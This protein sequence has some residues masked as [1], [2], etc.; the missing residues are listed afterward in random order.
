MSGPSPSPSSQTGGGIN[1]LDLV[2]ELEP[3]TP[4][5]RERRLDS[6]DLPPE[7]RRE[8]ERCLR[9]D[10][11]AAGFLERPPARL[12]GLAADPGTEI[13]AADARGASAEPRVPGYQVLSPLG[14]GG[15]GTVW[16]AV[17]LGTRRE[18]ALKLMHVSV[19]GQERARARFDREVQIAARLEHPHI[20]RVYDSGVHQGVYYYAMELVEGL[21]L[22]EYTASA[23]L[24]RRQILD[25]MRAVCRAVQHAHQNGVIHRDLK[26][27]NILVTKDGQPKVL[28]FGLARTVSD[29]GSDLTVTEEGGLAGTPAYMSPEQ[30][31]GRGERLDTRSDVYSLGVVLY[32]LLTGRSPHDLTGTRLELL[33]RISEREITSTAGPA[34]APS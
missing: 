13:T 11:S 9:Y 26:P 10:D 22:D 8:V 29:A 18:V 5:E 4:D 7:Q 12:G 14:E 1:V 20:A 19:F 2:D 32:R 21:P 33:R 30:A 15:M 16:R 23:K 24:A 31:A 17:Q 3:L 28:D 34:L 25:L 27:S 6:L